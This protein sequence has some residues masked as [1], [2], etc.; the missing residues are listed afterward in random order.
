MVKQGHFHAHIKTVSRSKGYSAVAA[1]AYQS[2]Q[3]LVHEKQRIF[4]VDLGYDKDKGGVTADHRKKLNKGIITEDLRK[5][6]AAG[7][8]TLGEDVTARKDGRSNWTIT[9]GALT[10]TV[11]EFRHRVLNRETRKREDAALK[12]DVYA[13]RTHNYT[14]RE[15]V[16][17]TWV[18]APAYAPEWVKNIEAKSGAVEK[19]DREAL[20]NWA[21]SAEI[22]RDARTAR[23]FQLALSRGLSYDQNIGLLRQYVN[24]QLTPHGYISDVA[25][26]S[27]K[28]SD[29][30]ENLH[31]H[32]LITTRSLME[33]GTLAANKTAP[34]DDHEKVEDRHKAWGKQL[35]TWRAAWAEKQNTALET[36]DSDTRVDHRSYQEQGVDIIPTEHVGAAEWNKGKRGQRTEAAERNEAIEQENVKKDKYYKTIEKLTRFGKSKVAAEPTEEKP[37]EK[38]HYAGRVTVRRWFG[39]GSTTVST[40]YPGPAS[41]PPKKR[42][43]LDASTPRLTSGE[44]YERLSEAQQRNLGGIFKSEQ[45]GGSPPETFK[46]LQRVAKS[47]RQKTEGAKSYVGE[48]LKSW[49]DRVGGPGKNQRSGKSDQNERDR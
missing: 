2:G 16:K 27:K 14:T 49:R 18:Q 26:H 21:E 46:H 25:I 17:E 3:D 20:W 10:Y 4:S 13:N 34:W 19:K 48:S 40:F 5:E 32:I 31:A 23:T 30:K 45:S 24:E 1:A 28:A 12:L 36:A 6:F 22:A 33:D 38:E 8:V 42:A 39:L 29:G 9:D 47:I 43:A 37:A 41:L 7:G 44:I 15:D 35:R 11:K